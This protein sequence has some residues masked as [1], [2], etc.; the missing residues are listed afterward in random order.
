MSGR[1]E[2]LRRAAAAGACAAAA[3]TATA[4]AGQHRPPSD[5]DRITAA[6]AEQDAR[7]AEQERLLAE[8]RAEIERQRAELARLRAEQDEALATVRATGARS[9]F[10]VAVA[11][12]PPPEP[13]V[14]TAGPVGEAPPT[15]PGPDLVAIPEGM[16]VLTGRRRLIIDPSIEYTRAS[17]NRVVFRG[18]VIVPGI[19]IGLL[20][21]NNAD[22]DAF[23][24]TLAGR[25]GLTDR[26]EIEG[27]IPYLRRTDIVTTVAP[28]T[29]DDEEDTAR[30]I[31][32]EGDGIGDIEAALRYQLN[33]GA[34]GRPIFVAG[35]RV[36][37]DTGKGAFDIDRD[38]FGIATELATGSGF[39]GVEPNITMLLAS[40]PV[41]IFANASY[42]FHLARDIDQ[43]ITPT[44]RVGE[45]DPGDSIG[46]AAGFG[47]ALNPRFSYSLGY[48]HN[49]VFETTTEL[50]GV[51]VD[52]ERLQIGALLV[53][54]SYR[55]NER[56][57][58]N[59]SVELGATA[60]APDVRVLFRVPVAF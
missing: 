47:F 2:T 19:N 48:R 54:M 31:D 38:R 34:G 35:L 43:A 52:S 29:G 5:L 26:L 24:A 12:T 15:E 22:R 1:V 6:L 37:S 60:D 44:V 4:A 59:S 32:I 45:V 53:A 55:L 58:L 50:N 33:D 56:V 41:V 57:T 10:D 27:R 42:L 16:G 23:V 7:L 14:S 36:K 20:E 39:W 49:V 11:Q 28:P 40:D 21:A 51:E 13:A 8:Q 25:F 46:L 18:E 3:L 9:A 30:T 17:T